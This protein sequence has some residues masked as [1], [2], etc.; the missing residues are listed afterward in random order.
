MNRP[1]AVIEVASV[2]KRFGPITAVDDVSA[3]I[4]E[5][6]FF[7][8]LGPSGCGKTTLLRLIAGFE[9]P[10]AGSILLDGRDI[11]RVRPNRRPVNMMFQ[12]YALF[13]HLT[14][15]RNVAYGLEME[16]VREPELSR[17]VNEALDLVQLADLAERRPHQLSGGQ[18]QRVA[19]ARALVK[20]PR[21]LLLDEPL[22]ALDRKLRE[23]MQFELKRLQ[24]EVGITFLVVTHDQEEAMAMADRIALLDRG[25]IAQLDTPRGLY[26]RPA[27]RFVAGFIGMMNFL[28]G[29]VAEIGNGTAAIEVPGCGLLSGTSASALAMG[30]AAVLAVRPERVRL[31]LSPLPGGLPGRVAGVAYLGQDLVLQVGLADRPQPLIVRLGSADAIASQVQPGIQVWCHWSE[32]DAGILSD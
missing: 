10:D 20:R 32:P 14:V 31:S 18:R 23:Q 24:H 17:R 9:Q 13:P 27:T 12:S 8:L 15:R 30:Q 11:T 4:R 7:A 16:A 1:A 21:V 29:R 3:A 25:R 28:G 2:T 22:A 6:E 19:L 26:E 5:G